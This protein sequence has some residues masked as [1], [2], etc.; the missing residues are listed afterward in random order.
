MNFALA[1]YAYSERDVKLE[2]SSPLQDARISTHAIVAAYARSFNLL[3]DSA[4]FDMVLPYAWCSGEATYQGAPQQRD[5][6]G[7]GDPTLRLTWDFIG[8][9]AM[10]L[11]Q[12]ATNRPNWI[13]GASF[14]L[15]LPL[16]QYDDDRLLNIGA[17]HQTLKFTASTGTTA[18][19][20]GKFT[21]IGI[22]WQYRW[23]GHGP[24]PPPPPE[25]PQPRGGK[26]A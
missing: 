3:G 4:K 11:A 12:A 21:S 1:G 17:N 24:P 16:G 9:P 23:G 20:G 6:S 15:G 7:F 14:R 8:A 10:S 13:V 18:R 19:I 25:N 22:V 5:V 2:A 26:T